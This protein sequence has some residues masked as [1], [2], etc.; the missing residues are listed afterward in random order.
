MIN[1]WAIVLSVF[2]VILSLGALGLAG[3]AVI[4]VLAMKNSTHKIQYID[5]MAA[6]E[7]FND[8]TGEDLAEEIGSAFGLGYEKKKDKNS[9]N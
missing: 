1:I 3:Y 4:I 2:S 6:V 7:P 9:I 5:P 8:H